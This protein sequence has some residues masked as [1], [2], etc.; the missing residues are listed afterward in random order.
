MVMPA[1]LKVKISAH[2]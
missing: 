2:D 1:C